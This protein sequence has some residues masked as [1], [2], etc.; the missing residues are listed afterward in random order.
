MEHK[1][2]FFWVLSAALCLYSGYN[3]THSSL[4]FGTALLYALT[5]AVLARAVFYQSA[6]RFFA[7]LPGHIALG[8]L[9]ALG[10]A[11]LCVLAFVLWN[12]YG[13]APTG[14]EKAMV[15]LGAGLR[16][17]KPSRLLRERLDTAY[18]YYC[19]HPELMIVT[20]GGQGRDELRPE[21]AAMRDYLIE[22]G[23]PAQNIISEEKSTSTEENFAFSRELMQ[24]AGLGAEEPILLVTNDFHCYRGKQYAAMAGFTKV[25]AIAAPTPFTAVLP[26]YLREV[27]ALVYFWLFRSSRTGFLHPFVGILSAG[28]KY[29]YYK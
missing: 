19:E 21:G 20:T 11:A 4:N 3:L 7:T 29:F 12:A 16:G 5:L 22:K 23:V 27:A 6:G 28:K 14:Q 17:D 1:Q 18:A 15:V 25:T 13:Y 10:A 8:V 2:L 26:C 9:G 24:K